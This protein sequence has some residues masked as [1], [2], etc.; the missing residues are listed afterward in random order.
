MEGSLR[1][2]LAR[3]TK[4]EAG[5]GRRGLFAPSWLGSPNGKQDEDDGD[6]EEDDEKPEKARRG[7]SVQ[8]F[9]VSR[10]LGDGSICFAHR[11]RHVF[12]DL[13]L[14]VNLLN[15]QWNGRRMCERGGKR[16]EEED[17]E[18]GGGRGR[19]RRRGTRTRR[20]RNRRREALRNCRGLFLSLYS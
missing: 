13:V 18:G 8:L 5:R 4:R 9:R 20:R 19:R 12:Q 14:Q 17:E 10:F 11:R 1:P 15:K 2:F 16:K 7:F 3:F 6:E